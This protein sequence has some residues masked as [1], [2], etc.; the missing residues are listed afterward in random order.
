M[1]EPDAANKVFL[2]IYD[3]GGSSAIKHMN[4]TL[5]RLGTG[6]YHTGIE[7]HGQ[8]WSYAIR[9]NSDC[10]RQ[11]GCGITVTQPC[12]DPSHCYRESVL[13][14]ETDLSDEEVAQILRDML[15]AWR[16]EQYNFLN[17]NCQTFCSEFSKHLQCKPLPAWV[18]SAAAAGLNLTGAFAVTAE[19]NASGPTFLGCRFSSCASSASSYQP[20]PKAA[21]NEEGY[22]KITI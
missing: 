4:D 10:S 18:T 21:V 3:V 22:I 12:E 8:E 2:H 1:L 20:V 15:P 11:A 14:G 16:S 6:V 19:E 17:N 5:R 9:L 7:V 13:L